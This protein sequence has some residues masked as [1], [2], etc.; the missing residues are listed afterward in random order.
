MQNFVAIDGLAN[1]NIVR[2]VA[3]AALQFRQQRNYDGLVSISTQLLQQRFRFLG[4]QADSNDDDK[5]FV[6]QWQKDESPKA[7]DIIW[8]GHEEDLYQSK[9]YYKR[10]DAETLYAMVEFASQDEKHFVVVVAKEDGAEEQEWKYHNTK[11]I[12]S[13][14]WTDVIQKEWDTRIEDAERRFLQNLTKHNEDLK[15]KRKE[16]QHK[17][18]GKSAIKRSPSREDSQG[19]LAPDDYWGDW[20][21][22]NPSQE[23]SGESEVSSDADSED[24]EDVYYNNWSNH[25]VENEGHSEDDMGTEHVAQGQ[26]REM[27]SPSLFKQLDFNF[28]ADSPSLMEQEEI[29]EEYDNSHNPLFTVPSVPNLMDMHTSALQELTSILNTTIQPGEGKSRAINMNP[30]PKVMYQRQMTDDADYDYESVSRPESIKHINQH[31]LAADQPELSSSSSKFPWFSQNGSNA[32]ANGSDTRETAKSFL[33]KSL[34]ALI[35]VARMLG[36]TGQQ[37][38]EMVDQI[39]KQ[40]PDGEV[41]S[42]QEIVAD[43]QDKK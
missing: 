17:K 19:R 42:Q 8:S 20:S 23:A 40:Q 5:D 34:S 27:R 33:M 16:K 32:E 6:V 14:E 12:D 10:S 9:I 30:L 43:D 15:K 38:S 13:T 3:F 31:Q 18:N 26:T 1:E 11:V 35:G 7:I 36:F 21:S 25:P 39:V 37:I 41:Q 22:E 24:S 28:K 29:Q 4:T 2:S